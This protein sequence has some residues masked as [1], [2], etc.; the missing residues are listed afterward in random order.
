MSDTGEKYYVRAR[1]KGL[2]GPMTLDEA[3]SNA[4]TLG[5]KFGN[6]V[7]GVEIFA[8]VETVRAGDDEDIPREFERFLPEEAAQRAKENREQRGNASNGNNERGNK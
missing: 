3:R 6:N 4:A 7:K 5:S 8:K 2:L 1:G